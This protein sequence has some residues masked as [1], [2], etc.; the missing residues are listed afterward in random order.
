MR[1][2]ARFTWSRVQ[3]IGYAKKWALC[4]QA[5]NDQLKAG[6][7]KAAEKVRARSSL[8]KTGGGA[9]RSA[10]DGRRGGAGS[11]EVLRSLLGPNCP[12]SGCE[13]C[14]LDPMWCLRVSSGVPARALAGGG[15]RAP[16]AQDG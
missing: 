10:G 12:V 6:F 16:P 5:A 13:H 14:Q 8:T 2:L 1:S 9:H 4:Q 3:V 7:P 15:K 11:V